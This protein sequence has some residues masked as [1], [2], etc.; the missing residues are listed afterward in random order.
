MDALLHILLKLIFVLFKTLFRSI[1]IVFRF[2]M[3]IFIPK[4]RESLRK[5]WNSSL[6]QKLGMV[7]G[8]L[9]SLVFLWTVFTFTLGMVLMSKSNV[10]VMNNVS[11]D[12]KK[13]SE[14]EYQEIMKS[15]G[16]LEL[17]NTVDKIIERKKAD[18]KEGNKEKSSDPSRLEETKQAEDVY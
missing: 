8:L 17:K 10:G 6:I 16:I 3:G 2:V 1:S 11:S 7:L 9:L 18:Q 14:E 5:E 13:L 15:K 12:K 4:Y